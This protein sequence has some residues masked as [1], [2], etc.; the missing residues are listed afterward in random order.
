MSYP[1]MEFINLAVAPK[2]AGYQTAANLAASAAQW[3]GYAVMSPIS[4]KRAMF[5]V[6]TAVSANSTAPQVAV[7]SRPTY[8]SATGA[9]T[10]V[11]VTVPSGS[12]AGQVIYASCS[13]N[14]RI[15]A[16]YELS[17][18][19]SV[20]AVDGNTATGAGFIGCIYEMSPDA[21]ANQALLVAASQNVGN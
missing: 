7:K 3:Q 20:Q 6:T 19:V 1:E 14:V 21:N 12:T 16:G 9:V 18:E 4:I 13:D 5:F 2:S 15:Q 8:G 10:V 17:L 11:S